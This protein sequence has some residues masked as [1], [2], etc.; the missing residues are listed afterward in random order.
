MNRFLFLTLAVISPQIVNAEFMLTKEDATHISATEKSGSNYYFKA[1]D[2]SIIST[3]NQDSL[4][5]DID[6]ACDDSQGNLSTD[7]IFTFPT[8]GANSSFMV[9]ALMAHNANMNSPFVPPPLNPPP[10]P[11]CGDGNGGSSPRSTPTLSA[12]P[13]SGCIEDYEAR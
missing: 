13:E 10:P 1:C 7:S 12:E 3:H 2:N 5:F 8:V 11:R 4:S 6:A 9:P